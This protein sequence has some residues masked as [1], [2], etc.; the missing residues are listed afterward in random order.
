MTVREIARERVVTQPPDASVADVVRTM[1]R[2]TVHSVVITDDGT[3][4][5]LVTDRDLALSVLDEEFD[6][7]G[8]PIEALVPEEPTTVEASAGVYEL[9]ELL[10]RT[11][12]RRVP[13]VED[14]DLVGLVSLSDVV[15]LLGMELQHVAN[16]IRASAPAYERS[17][18][19]FY[20]D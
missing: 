19:T 15:V 16:A 14:G 13:V 8:T 12:L 1:H 10:S 2:E 5:G 17:A 7:E 6:A 9:V 11:G 20:D 4:V 3:P 18:T